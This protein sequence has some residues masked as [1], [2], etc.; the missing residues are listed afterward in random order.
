MVFSLGV[1]GEENKQENT[2]IKNKREKTVKRIN[3]NIVAALLGGIAFV[4]IYGIKILNPL[5]TDW[6]LTGGDPSQHYLGWEFSGDQA[7]ISLWD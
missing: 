1:I 6:L 5:Y 3:I 7:G 2:D 4:L